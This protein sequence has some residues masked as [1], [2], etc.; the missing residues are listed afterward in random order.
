VLEEAVRHHPKPYVREKAAALLKLA[1]GQL[2]SFVAAYGL[3]RVHDPDTLHDWVD[4]F[5]TEGI[6]GLLV[7]K[8]GG[9][10]PTFPPATDKSVRRA[11]GRASRH[12]SGSA[13][14]R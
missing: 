4:R 7:R 1:D 6:G 11:R 5:L 2:Y 12:T 8:G 3:L 9:R 14:T 10:K 13:P